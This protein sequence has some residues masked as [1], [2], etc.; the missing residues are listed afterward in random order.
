M[1][2]TNFVFDLFFFNLYCLFIHKCIILLQLFKKYK[3]TRENVESHSSEGE[4]TE[5][6]PMKK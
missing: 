3:F 5:I 2:K 1:T 6:Q 4:I